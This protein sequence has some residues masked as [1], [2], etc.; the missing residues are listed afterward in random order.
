MTTILTSFAPSSPLTAAANRTNAVAGES[1]S[2]SAAGNDTPSDM[3]GLKFSWSFGDGGT[4]SGANVTHVFAT[5]GSYNV[6]VEVS[7]PDGEKA[8]SMIAV[9]ILPQKKPAPAPTGGPDIALVAAGA[10]A[11]AIIATVAAFA[12]LRA[13]ASRR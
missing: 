11:A 4:G 2:F 12:V 9:Q 7:D 10:A 1:I 5:E 6:R 13:R 3:S 8:E